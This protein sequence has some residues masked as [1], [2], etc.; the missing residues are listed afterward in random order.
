M[1]ARTASNQNEMAANDDRNINVIM[2]DN[3]TPNT[4]PD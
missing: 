2:T 1:A 3:E 4:M